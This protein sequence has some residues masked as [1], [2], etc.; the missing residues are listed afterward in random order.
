MWQCTVVYRL[1]TRYNCFCNSC[2]DVLRFV[3][4]TAV[5]T[6]A[7]RSSAVAERPHGA[8]GHLIFH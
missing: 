7:T 2:S 8:S 4:A 5:A 1:N 6:V 3:L